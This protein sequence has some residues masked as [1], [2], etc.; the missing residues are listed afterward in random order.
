MNI[1][2]DEH[3]K[4]VDAIITKLQGLK[5]PKLLQKRVIT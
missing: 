4:N 2:F 1:K 3:R 5:V